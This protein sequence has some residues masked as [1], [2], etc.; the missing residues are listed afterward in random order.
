M[1]AFESD[2]GYVVACRVA[3]QLAGRSHSEGRRDR[4]G[5][6]SGAESVVGALAHL[7]EAAEAAVGAYR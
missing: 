1:L 6:V 2:D 3:L 5:A 4:R 7:R